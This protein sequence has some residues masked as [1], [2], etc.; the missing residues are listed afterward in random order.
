MFCLPHNSGE[1]NWCWGYLGGG[2]LPRVAQVTTRRRNVIANLTIVSVWLSNVYIH[3]GRF[4]TM[5]PSVTF[6]RA[7]RENGRAY[8]RKNKQ[9]CSYWFIDVKT[10]GQNC[11]MRLRK[12]TMYLN[13]AG[14][15]RSK[16]IELTTKE[17]WPCL[18]H[19]FFRFDLC[20]LIRVKTIHVVQ[21]A[22]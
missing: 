8:E 11:L 16:C 5:S 22:L 2:E 13:R 7:Q 10:D 15:L 4:W 6:T 19:L 21:S 17:C 12:N 3:P 14:A 20:N 1:D 9:N 18:R